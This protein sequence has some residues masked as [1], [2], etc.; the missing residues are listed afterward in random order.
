MFNVSTSEASHS[1]VVADDIATVTILNDDYQ[2][3]IQYETWYC[4]YFP[5]PKL[6]SNILSAGILTNNID[7]N[8]GGGY[9]LDS[10]RRDQVVVKLTGSFDAWNIWSD[11]HSRIS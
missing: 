8:W 10:G 7:Y 11:L 9:V 5:C 1:S 3:G 2:Q 4:P 6:S